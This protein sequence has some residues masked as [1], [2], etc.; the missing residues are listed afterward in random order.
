[1]TQQNGRFWI[2]LSSSD[3]FLDKIKKELIEDIMKISISKISLITVFSN[4]LAKR[5]KQT[6]D[7]KMENN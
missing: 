3:L 6:M 4:Y 7:Y 1:M 5:Y 2:D